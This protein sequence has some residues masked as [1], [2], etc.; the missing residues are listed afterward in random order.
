MP[1]VLEQ[2]LFLFPQDVEIIKYLLENER[3]SEVRGRAMWEGMEARGVGGGRR[4]WQSLK[5]RFLKRIRP[6]LAKYERGEDGGVEGLT[7]NKRAK[8]AIS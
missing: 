4:S 1:Q 6:N 7:P 8:L 3:W 5:E 2:S